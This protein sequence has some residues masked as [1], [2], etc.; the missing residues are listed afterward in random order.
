MEHHIVV[1]IVE[2]GVVTVVVVVVAVIVIKDHLHPT[3]PFI[4][5]REKVEVKVEIGILISP[6]QK[7]NTK[8]RLCAKNRFVKLILAC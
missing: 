1:K 3:D 2:I 7:K 5:A 6:L 4:T 8:Y